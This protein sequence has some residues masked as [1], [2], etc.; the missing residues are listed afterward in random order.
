[1]ANIRCDDYGY[2]CNYVSHGNVEKMV[3]DFWEHVNNKHGID[4]SKETIVESIKRK[5]PE[6][7]SNAP[8]KLVQG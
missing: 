1:M 8:K 2:E 6:N 5:N 7:Y 3:F 4:Y